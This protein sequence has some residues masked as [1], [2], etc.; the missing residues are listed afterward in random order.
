MKHTCSVE[1]RRFLESFEAFELDAANFRH[2]EH[3]RIAYILLSTHDIES[4]RIRLKAAL[5]GY[6]SHIGAGEE[7][8]HETLTTAWLL[9]VSHFMQLSAP[10][11]C[12]DDFIELNDKLLDSSIMLTHYSRKL[13]QTTRARA[14]FMAPDLDPIPIHETS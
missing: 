2:R 1:D 11:S 13:L 9:A 3:L 5:L 7:K 12:F 10:S 6:L 4:A 8:Y 14:V